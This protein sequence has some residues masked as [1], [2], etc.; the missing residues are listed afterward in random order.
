MIILTECVS[1]TKA[2]KAEAELDKMLYIQKA[3]S[4]DTLPYQISKL[5]DNTVKELRYKTD[6]K[7]QK[8]RREAERREKQKREK[9]RKKREEEK[10]YLKPGEK[11]IGYAELCR[12][13]A[14]ANPPQTS[15]SEKEIARFDRMS[16]ARLVRWCHFSYNWGWVIPC[17]LLCLVANGGLITAIGLIVPII[18]FKI[19]IM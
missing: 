16:D 3:F 1:D 5:M 7:L 8:E 14:K 2:G 15:L 13:K 17:L 9:E 12:R 6:P 10:K 11:S 18:T 4:I 19:P